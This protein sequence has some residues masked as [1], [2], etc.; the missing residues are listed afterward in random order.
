M[1]VLSDRESERVFGVRMSRRRVQAVW[2]RVV[3]GTDEAL[4]LDLVHIDPE[5]YT[6]LEAAYVNHFGTGKRLLGFGLLA[7]HFL[8]FL[9]LVPFKYFGARAANRRMDA[10]FKEHGFPNG[11]IKPGG[12]ISGF[13]YTPLDEGTKEVDVQLLAKDHPRNFSFSVTIPGLA[14]DRSDTEPNG[15]SGNEELDLDA[16]RAYLEG[17]ARC[18]TNKK[19]SLEGD[20]LNLVVV[21]DRSAVLRCF[22]AR[23]DEAETITFGTSWKTTK[24]FF[25]ESQYRYSPVSPLF[26]DGRQQEL[27]LQKARASINER[28]HLRLWRATVNFEGA[29]VWIGQVSRDI[30]VR[31]TPKTWNL[32][33]HKIDPD[34]DEARDYVLNDLMGARRASRVGYVKGVEEAPPSA[35]R[36]NLT[37]DPYVTDGLRAVAILSPSRTHASFLPWD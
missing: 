27:A 1:S 9:A 34:V 24:A 26:L 33:T 25:L 30:G 2:L 19:G 37:G 3:N 13:I 5:Y 29:P 20:P 35:P 8:P 17:Q 14:V 18:T 32:T 12:D 31:F 7:V 36:R 22:G 28:I 4:R 10:F 16:L 15:L 23:W 11:P 21:G 6:S